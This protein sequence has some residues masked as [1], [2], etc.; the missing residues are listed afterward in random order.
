MN[1]QTRTGMLQR[2][3]E[4]KAQ[5]PTKKLYFTESAILTSLALTE[6]Q[7]NEY[8]IIFDITPVE[9]NGIKMILKE[10]VKPI[11]IDLIYKGLLNNGEQLL[12]PDLHCDEVHMFYHGME[13]NL[14]LKYN[15]IERSIFNQ[16]YRSAFDKFMDTMINELGYKPCS[17][18]LY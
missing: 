12:R 4:E 16:F 2:P 18:K 11:A 6:L 17:Q 8:C 1:E 3:A 13:D 5:L 7:L 9:E 15:G 14:S 10:E